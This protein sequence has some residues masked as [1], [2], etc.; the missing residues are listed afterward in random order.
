MRE[1]VKQSLTHYEYFMYLKEDQ[2]AMCMTGFL[3][4]MLSCIATN[5]QAMY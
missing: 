1:K 3:M 4:S 5:K 2:D